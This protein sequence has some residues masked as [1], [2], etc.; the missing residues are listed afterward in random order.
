MEIVNIAHQ[1]RAVG[2]VRAADT[3]E[4]GDMD[5]IV[6]AVVLAFFAVSATL[7]GLLDRL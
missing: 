7:V 6:I 5:L 4:R 3:K 1:G 2:Y